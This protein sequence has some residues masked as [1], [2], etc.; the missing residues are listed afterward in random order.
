[1]NWLESELVVKARFFG[2]NWTMS[3]IIYLLC[4]GGLLLKSTA[5]LSRWLDYFETQRWEQIVA[6]IKNSK[7][8]DLHSSSL[9]ALC[10]CVLTIKDIHI[11]SCVSIWSKIGHIKCQPPGWFLSKITV[12]KQNIIDIWKFITNWYGNR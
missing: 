9:R 4:T 2:P 5:M 3:Q 8:L 7:W 12:K 1:M 6:W 11:S 10:T